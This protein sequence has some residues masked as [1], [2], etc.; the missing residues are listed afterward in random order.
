MS[1]RV[2][3]CPSCGYGL[4]VPAEAGLDVLGA[5]EGGR[6]AVAAVT[7][8]RPS[9]AGS[10]VAVVVAAAVLAM[11]L[12]GRDPSGDAAP[13]AADATPPT[14]VAVAPPS[15][16]RKPP[17]SSLPRSTSPAAGAPPPI[18]VVDTV[19]GAPF[20]G[21]AT[22]LVLLY[23]SPTAL[24]VLDLDTGEVRKLAE[25]GHVPLAVVAEQLVVS[26]TDSGAWGVLP[27]RLDG[28]MADPV[29]LAVGGEV[30]AARADGL[31]WSGEHMGVQTRWRLLEL[32]TNRVLEMFEVP[33]GPSSYVNPRSWSTG[34]EVIDA[35]DGGVYIRDGSSFRR[36]AE[37]MLLAVAPDSVLLRR[38]GP[39]L[40]CGPV[41]VDRR[42]W[43]DIDA[44]VPPGHFDEAA[45]SPGARWVRTSS[46]NEDSSS[47]FDRRTGAST[48]TGAGSA[49]GPWSFSPDDRYLAV[50]HGD[51]S[52]TVVELATGERFAIPVRLYDAWSILLIPR[53][54]PG[55]AGPWR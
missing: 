21:R 44:P 13:P 19:E 54:P 2:R 3:F 11:G 20:L 28:A 4:E 46:Y 16:S 8:V 43:R 15:T 50:L 47:V 27:W 5:D 12:L 55:A 25:A 40:R 1:G 39:D 9:R 34:P 22:G 52:P 6:V 23:G 26:L 35:P 30:I 37:G 38:C 36:V 53:P 45:V 29:P 32:G 24:Q 33:S 41:W 17:P 42:T 49:F 10:V 51:A 31:V 48:T 14:T 18:E 7:A